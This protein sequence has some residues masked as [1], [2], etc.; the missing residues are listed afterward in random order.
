MGTAPMSDLARHESFA[1]AAR[2][3]ALI[4]WGRIAD[5]RQ[6]EMK[7]HHKPTGPQSEADLIADRTILETLQKQ[8]PLR[9][10]GYLTEETAD[11]A[12][13]LSREYVWIID[14]IDGTKHF[15][16]GHDDF[17]MH[18]ALVRAGTDGAVP[19]ASAVY[20]PMHGRMYTAWQEGGAWLEEEITSAG[21]PH[22][23]EGRMLLDRRPDRALFHAPR[24]VHSRA[25]AHLTDCVMMISHNDPKRWLRQALSRIPHSHFLRRGSVGLKMAEVAIGNADIYLTIDPGRCNEWDAAAPHLI[26]TEAGGRVTDR[27]GNAILYNQPDPEFVGG[28]VATNGTCHDFVVKLLGGIEFQTDEES[29]ATPTPA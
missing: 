10:Y 17:S 21:E 25:V 14:P 26:V 28:L 5:L 9:T 3:A 15:L 11:N 8:F 12:E 4:A 6:G 20:A 24:R 1:M 23:W 18:I 7:I 2:D 22:W 29:T 13:R 19:V 27:S 16:R